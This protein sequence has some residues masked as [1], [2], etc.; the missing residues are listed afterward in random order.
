MP[1]KRRSKAKRARK[2]NPFADTAPVGGLKLRAAA[3]YLGGLHPSTMRKLV[4]RGLL[5]PNRQL[6]HLIFSRIEL[7]R[8]LKEGMTE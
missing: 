3:Q 2:A 4:A 1:T 6:R 5:R 8:F 7:D